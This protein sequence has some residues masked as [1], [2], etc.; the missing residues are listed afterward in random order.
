MGP[1]AHL[2]RLSCCSLRLGRWLA[3]TLG[4]EPTRGRCFLRPRVDAAAPMN[5]GTIKMAA[6][7]SGVLKPSA[8]VTEPY[9]ERVIR[10]TMLV[11]KVAMLSQYEEGHVAFGRGEREDCQHGHDENVN[12]GAEPACRG[13]GHGRSFDWPRSVVA[14]SVSAWTVSPG[15]YRTVRTVGRTPGR[16]VTPVAGCRRLSI[17]RRGTP[18]AQQEPTGTSAQA[19]VRPRGQQGDSAHERRLDADIQQ[20]GADRVLHGASGQSLAEGLRVAVPVGAGRAGGIG[21]TDW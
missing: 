17:Y 4:G 10:T 1:A 15:S 13:A 12:T 2:C 21:R 16:R 19:T 11:A 8:V 18:T 6:S 5:S 20:N 9:A 3:S 7:H 14:F